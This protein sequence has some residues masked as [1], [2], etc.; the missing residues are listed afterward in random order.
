MKKGGVRG[1]GRIFPRKG[2]W[3]V[4]ISYGTIRIRRSTGIQVAERK[5]RTAA[6][7]VLTGLL[8]EI[9]EGRHGQ[10]ANKVTP[11]NELVELLRADYVRR[12]LRSW[13]RAERAIALVRFKKG[14][15]H[16]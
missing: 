12:S 11:F 1:T 16:R 14:I 9:R 7:N 2:Y 5:S 15:D 4:D 8:Q 6:Q 3:H 13:D 10:S